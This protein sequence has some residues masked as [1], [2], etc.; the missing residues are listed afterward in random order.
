MIASKT[1][2]KYA[3]Y[4]NGHIFSLSKTS[5]TIISRCPFIFYQVN[6]NK[7]KNDFLKNT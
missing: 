2:V 5:L 3:T 1:M 7:I 6:E 4:V